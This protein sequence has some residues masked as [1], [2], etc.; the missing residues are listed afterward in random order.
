MTPLSA[1]NAS[2]VEFVQSPAFP[3]VGAK[4]ALK[5][6]TLRSI[7][8]GDIGSAAWDTT[9]LSALH[10]LPRK[11][12]GL[13][14]FAS[15]AILFPLTPRLTEEAF[16]QALW[17]RLSALHRLDA[18]EFDWDPKFNDDPESPNFGMSFGGRGFYVIG[19]HPNASRAARRMD[20]AT[21][22]F[23]PHSQFEELRQVGLF[24]KI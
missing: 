5:S 17:R 22:I 1:I 11:C 10:A 3:C 4:S 19:M 9:I 23:N 12:A 24:D 8:C 21:L 16:E 18:A 7:E 14:K 20:C 2:L 13:L 15:L 6:G